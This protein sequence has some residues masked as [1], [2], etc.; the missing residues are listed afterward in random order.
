MVMGA[1]LNV[2][3]IEEI[4]RERFSGASVIVP[5]QQSMVDIGL[6][7]EIATPKS[8][9]RKI[10]DTDNLMSFKVTH[11]SETQKRPVRIFWEN[12][13]EN[14]SLGLKGTTEVTGGFQE[15]YEFHIIVD[16]QEMEAY[17]FS[18]KDI[19]NSFQKRLRK[20]GILNLKNVKINLSKLEDI[21]E[22]SNIWG[23]WEDGVGRCKKQAL[24]GVEVNKENQHN[25]LK[26]TSYN[27][28]YD[29]GEEEID[30][31]I[32]STGGLSSRSKQIT[33][34]D[35]LTIYKKL[36]QLGAVAQQD[37]NEE[38]EEE[39]EVDEADEDE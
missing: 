27:L 1:S 35:L 14:T 7:D 18:K 23:I 12:L 8:T 39:A 36:K 6:F 16:L 11:H 17:I 13:Q 20:E 29:F 31:I 25:K 28:E 37:L 24:F 26:A 19:A 9:L 21:P 3:K 30:L 38:E 34:D 2:F 22:A 5:S 32:T 4:K 33:E 10:K 15:I